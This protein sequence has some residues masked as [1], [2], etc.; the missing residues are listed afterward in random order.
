M[1]S[2]YTLFFLILALWS[3]HDV[4]VGYL[5]ADNAEYDPASVT[6]RKELDPI[7][8]ALRIKNDA[9][10]VS[11]KVQ[12]VLGT[13]PLSYEL[14]DVT[15]SEGGD[16]NLFM[17]EVIVRGGGIIELPLHTKVPK[18]HYLVSLRVYNDDYSAELKDAFT[19]IVE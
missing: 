19:F 4:K 16:K 12:G 11:P 7:D 3:C 9:N 2:I 10:W 6:V 15:V 18:G 5:K 17:Q 13:N 14:V 8:D 1:K